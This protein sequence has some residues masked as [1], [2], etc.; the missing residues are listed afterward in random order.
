MKSC[1]SK[2]RF[3]S[4]MYFSMAAP[5]SAYVFRPHHLCE[6]KG[7]EDTALSSSCPRDCIMKHALLLFCDMT[8]NRTWKHGTF[9]YFRRSRQLRQCRYYSPSPLISSRICAFLVVLIRSS[10]FSCRSYLHA[11]FVLLAHTFVR[12]VLI[13]GNRSRDTY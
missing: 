8:R 13:E 1:K 7:V 12:V 9:D 4:T 3:V 6:L 11:H 10:I 2:C 5:F